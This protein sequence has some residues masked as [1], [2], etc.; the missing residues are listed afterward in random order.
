MLLMSV[1]VELTADGDVGVE[2][3]A[4]VALEREANDEPLALRFLP[5][6]LEPP[7]RLVREQQQVRTIR[8]MDA[9]AAPARHVA[10]D[11]IA[12]HRLT[13]LR[14]PH[15]QPVDALDANALRRPRTRSTSRSNDVR[16]R[17]LRSVDVRDRDA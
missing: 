3:A 5:V 14:V 7:L 13:T 12:G 9:H 11:R 16:L 10:D 6:D 15:H 1:P 8:A 2:T 4:I 17:R